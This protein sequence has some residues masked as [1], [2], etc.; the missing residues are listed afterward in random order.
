MRFGVGYV[1]QSLIPACCHQHRITK[2]KDFGKG[3]QSFSGMN[4]TTAK[5]RVAPSKRK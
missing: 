1:I 4:P 5:V 3:L 2:K